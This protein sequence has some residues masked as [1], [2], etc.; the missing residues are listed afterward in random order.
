MVF[1]LLFF[2][3]LLLCLHAFFFLFFCLILQHCCINCLMCNSICSTIL[4]LVL[5]GLYKFTFLLS[6]TT[7]WFLGS[8]SAPLCGKGS[9][10]TWIVFVIVQNFSHCCTGSILKNQEDTFAAELHRLKQQPLFSL[11]DFESVVDWIRST[12]A[13]VRVA[14]RVTIQVEEHLSFVNDQEKG[15]CLLSIK[16]GRWNKQVAFMFL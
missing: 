5:Q 8:L 16:T 1:F 12:V 9:A 4:Y 10:L 13:E 7:L 6:D 15:G 11:V 2:S 14:G 3:P